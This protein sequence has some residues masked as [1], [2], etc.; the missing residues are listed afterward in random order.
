MGAA[1]R[2]A[3]ET[4]EQLRDESHTPPTARYP[5]FVRISVPLGAR[6]NVHELLRV[7]TVVSRP[8]LRRSTACDRDRPWGARARTP[9]DSGAAGVQADC[10]PDVGGVR[11]VSA[12]MGHHG[13]VS[14]TFHSVDPRTGEQG[15]LPGG[16]HRRRRRRRRRGRG[17]APLRRAGRRRAPRRAARG[18]R[19]TAARRRRR[20]RR[21]RGPRPACPRRACAASSSAPPASSRRSPR[22]S[23]GRPRRG[24]HRHPRPRA[25]PIPR[26]DMRRMLVPDR[27]GR[28]VRRQQLPARLL[29]R[30]RRH[31]QRP[32]RRLP[33]RG[34]GPPV[35]PGHRRASSRAS[36]RPRP[37]G[38]PA[39]GHVRAAA[40]RRRRGR[41]GARR[42]SPRSPRS[43][44]PARSAA[45]A[46]SSTAPPRR[47][48]PDPRLR[49]D[50]QRQ[51][52]RRHRGRARRARGR[53][54]RGPR[55][56]RSRTFGG[57]LCTK[58]GVVFVPAGAAGDAF[59][60]PSARGSPRASPRC[61]STS[62]CATR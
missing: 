58:P 59:A 60:A 57:Q 23:R 36:S 14:T 13:G 41:R 6:S 9:A 47:P 39:R 32:G 11:S 18:R 35:A 51:P 62:A 34:Q 56:R 44:S 28:R 24:D 49:R 61:C 43:A 1:T 16:D 5:P 55:R 45:A 31:R 4:C 22:S 12:R 19:P 2:P 53:D 15:R 21:R 8:P 38:R 48:R 54:R 29:R 26:P 33:R 10:G 52:D 46:R 27:A 25:Q 20:D 7:G 17:R 50:G 37:R 30:R 3:R 40:G 42:R